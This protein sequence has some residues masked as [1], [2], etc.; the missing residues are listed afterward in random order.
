M[1]LTAL[2]GAVAL[3]ETPCRLGLSRRMLSTPTQPGM[4]VAGE[5]LGRVLIVVVQA[6]VI[7]FGSSLLFGVNWGQPLGVAAIILLFALVASGAGILMGTLFR[8]EQQAAGISL[9]LGLGSLRWEDAWCHSKFSPTRCGGSHTSHRRRGGT[10]R[11]PSWLAM[12]L[13]SGGS[14]LSWVSS[15]GVCRGDPCACI[16]APETRITA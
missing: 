16:L 1:F 14:C 6:T 15:R 7:I 10:M 12:E 5:T 9:L 2:T 11:S 4:V 3:I 13:R 8:N